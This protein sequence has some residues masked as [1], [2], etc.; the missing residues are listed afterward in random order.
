MC[1]TTITMARVP[2]AIFCMDD[3]NSRD[4]DTDE[5]VLLSALREATGDVGCDTIDS[6]NP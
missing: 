5:T 2:S 1:A 6:K 3:P 4:I